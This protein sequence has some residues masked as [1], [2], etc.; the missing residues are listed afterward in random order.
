MLFCLLFSA[1]DWASTGKEDE[2]EE[3]DDVGREELHVRYSRR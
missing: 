1:G 3:D 2:K